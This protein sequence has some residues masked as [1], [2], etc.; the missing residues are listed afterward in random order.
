MR[1]MQLW[2]DVQDLYG[3]SFFIPPWIIFPLEDDEFGQLCYILAKKKSVTFF[4]R[5]GP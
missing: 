2:D 3:D 4:R 5:F 1:K